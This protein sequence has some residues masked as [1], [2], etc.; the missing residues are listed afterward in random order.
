[1]KLLRV[2]LVVAFAGA[3]L[4]AVA[5]AD[6]EATRQ[7]V[8]L[9]TQAKTTTTVSS[10]VFEPLGS[11]ALKLDAGKLSGPIPREQRVMRNGQA[12]SAYDGV[13]TFKGKRGTVV[14]RS[15]DEYADGGNGY[16]PGTGT[17]LVVRGTGQYAGLRGGGRGAHVW[18]DSGPWSS[19]LEGFVTLP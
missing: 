11:G 7:R 3:V 19:R 1:M 5:A 6:P 8:A 15:H 16:H 2:V 14:I 13:Y 12:I 17:W 4:T 10:A 9:T 18:L